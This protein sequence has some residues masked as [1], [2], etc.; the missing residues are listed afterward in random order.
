MFKQGDKVAAKFNGTKTGTVLVDQT[1]TPQTSVRVKWDQSG[2]ELWEFPDDLVLIPVEFKVGDPVQYTTLTSGSDRVGLRGRVVTAPAFNLQVRVLWEDGM[3]ST[4]HIT[5]ITKLEE[6]EVPKADPK[7][8]LYKEGDRVKHKYSRKSGTVKHD[9]HT[10]GHHIWVKWDHID[11][12]IS[13]KPE[14]LLTLHAPRETDGP[15]PYQAAIDNIEEG[16]TRLKKI[17]EDAQFELS[18]LT[19]AKKLLEKRDR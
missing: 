10:A 14:E 8:F 13:E 6:E 12:A 2:R 5:N 15:N 3:T 9:Q 7:V 18:G 1:P 17:I 4:A 19:Q 11:E 16:R